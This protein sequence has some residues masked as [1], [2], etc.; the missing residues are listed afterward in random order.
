M[1]IIAVELTD[2]TSKKTLLTVCYQPPN[3][4]LTEWFDLFTSF[5]QVTEN[6]ENVFIT[7]DFNFANLTWGSTITSN[8]NGTVSANSTEFHELIY[9]FFLQQVNVKN[10]Y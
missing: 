7:G 3:C 4:N 1:K 8:I 2:N 6:Y 10:I 5:L 9:D